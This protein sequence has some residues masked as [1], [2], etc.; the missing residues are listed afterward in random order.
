MRL[1]DSLPISFHCQKSSS[2]SSTVITHTGETPRKM[3]SSSKVIMGATLMMVISLAI[4]SGLVLVLLAELYCSLLLRRRRVRLPTSHS[5]STTTA[6]A[7]TTPVSFLCSSFHPQDSDNQ[8][9]SP[10]SSFYAQ[11]VLHAPRSFLFPQ[12]SPREAKNGRSKFHQVLQFH[13]KE[14][15][16]TSPRQIGILSP[17]SAS[18]SFGT[19]PQLIQEIPIQ[20]CSSSSATKEK[21]CGG[22]GGGGDDGVEHVVY[23]SNPIYDNEACRPSRAD[24]PFETPDSSPSHLEEPEE[25]ES[26]S[27]G[28]EE[29]AQPI[30]AVGLPITPPLSPMKKL[31]AEAC[32]ISLRD[33][34][35]LGTS[36]SDSN[37]NNG[38]SSSSSGTPCTSPSW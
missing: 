8:A 36:G 2:L 23:I 22:S 29:I 13:A 7:A 37:S 20:G 12:V 14:C 25:E 18:T 33:A 34:G 27:S 35:S 15:L 21:A 26:G 38:I 28:D 11:G 19:S 5:T 6:T 9:A 32:S 10:L 4:V 16:N 30:S 17:S 31:P 3:K 1:K 24:T